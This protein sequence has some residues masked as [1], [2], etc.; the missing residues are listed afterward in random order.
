[1]MVVISEPVEFHWDEGNRNKNWVKHK[2]SNFECEEVFQDA[3]RKIFGDRLHSGGEERFRIIG[4]TTM[5]RILFVVFTIRRKKIRII[6]ARDLNRKE[7]CLYE[8]ET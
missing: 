4:K 7:V 5:G 1:M 2:V 6:S 3:K 8:K